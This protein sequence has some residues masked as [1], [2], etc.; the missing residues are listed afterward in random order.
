MVEGSREIEGEYNEFREV[1][2]NSELMVGEGKLNEQGLYRSMGDEMKGGSIASECKSVN[3]EKKK[4]WKRIKSGATEL[5]SKIENC[6]RKRKFPEADLVRSEKVISEIDG[7]KRLK[8]DNIDG[9][10]A[11]EEEWRYTGFYGSPYANNKSGTWNLL[12]KLGQNRNHPWLASGDFNEIMYSYEKCGGVPREESRMEVFRE[13]L[14]ECLLEDLGYS[15]VWFTW[16]RGNLP[17]TNIRERLDRGVANDKWKQLFPMEEGLCWKVGKGTHISVNNDSWIPDVKKS[18]LLD[19]NLNLNEVKVADLINQNNRTWN[20]ELIFST[21][22]EDVAE[23]IICIPLA[24]IPHDDFQMEFT[25][26]LTWVFAKNSASQCRTFCCVLWA[27][28]G[29]RNDRV[30]KKVSKS[31]KA[32][33]RFVN[34]YIVELNEIDTNK[35]QS[36]IIIRKWRKSPDQFVKINFDAG[37]D[38]KGNQATVGIVARDSE[39]KTLL[40]CSEIYQ[41]VTS[42]FVAE[43]L[44]CRKVTKIGMDMNW[45]KIIIEGDSLS[46]IKKSKSSIQD[47]SRVCAY[48]T[49]I[50]KMLSEIKECRFEHVS[51]AVNILAHMIAKETMKAKVPVYLVGG[52]PEYAEDQKERDKMGD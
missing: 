17:E 9:S 2:E 3:H 40:S 37:Y 31:G 14:E 10:G 26:W 34:S 4:S 43:E 5:Q 21:F 32:L 12:K 1:Q 48:I 36:S 49:D 6:M 30:H 20:K 22:P 39:G 51:R 28:W 42:V 38:G 45:G 24:E 27:I 50:H 52:V 13:V 41:Q 35:S 18:R 47:K 23:K 44:A 15:G 33:G 29:D 19:L 16:E 7:T 11:V 46:I 25:Q 8:H